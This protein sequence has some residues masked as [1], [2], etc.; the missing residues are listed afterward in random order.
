[1]TATFSSALAPTIY[2]Y[3]TLKRALGRQYASQERILA[4]LDRFLTAR[5]ADL[6]PETFA[7]WCLTFEHL[8]SGVRRGWMREVRNTCLYRRRREPGCFVPDQRLFPPV[9]QPVRPHI[10][11]EGQVG[12][13]LAAA[14]RRG[15]TDNSPLCP[16]MMRLGIVLLYTTGMRRRELTRLTVGDYDPRER[17]L[18]IRESK[19]HKS[20]LIPVSGDA[21][22]EIA[23]LLDLRRQRRFP[24]GVDSPLLWH[25]YRAYCGGGVGCAIRALFRQTRIRTASGH[26]PRLHDFR[27]TFA[28][29]VLQRWYHAGHDVQAKLPF[30]AHYMGHVSIVS[31]AYYL[32]FIE[33]LAAAASTRFADVYG[34]LITPSVNGGTR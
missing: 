31:T 34:R 16:E 12:Q 26:L 22:C 21:A 4:H 33:P 15:P 13:P 27:H 17:T 20:R 24:V 8:A 19:F 11:T 2:S 7:A 28:L 32:H 9:H 6:G 5:G 10:F 29:T 18:L 30:L 23:H 25:R 14:R 3:L 1:M